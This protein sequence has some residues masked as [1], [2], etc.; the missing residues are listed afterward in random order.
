MGGM[1]SVSDST[2]SFERCC[3]VSFLSTDQETDTTCFGEFNKVL[4]T[5][6]SNAKFVIGH[7]YPVQMEP[8]E[9]F[10]GFPYMANNVLCQ[11]VRFWG[12]L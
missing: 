9:D 4:W 10:Q 5:A 12:R 8:L 11:R 3:M 1:L 7:L 2:V 6:P